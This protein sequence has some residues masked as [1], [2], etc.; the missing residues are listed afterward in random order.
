MLLNCHT[1]FSLRYGL[2]SVDELFDEVEKMGYS[3]F[4]LTDINNTSACM[5]VLRIGQR[6]QLKVWIGIDFRNGAEQKYVGI[7]QNMVGFRE[8]NEHLTHH[9]H[10]GGA[11]SSSA[12]EFENAYVVYP[13]DKQPVFLRENEFIGVSLAQVAQLG[14]S[15]S[16]YDKEK[17]VILHST[18][19]RHKRDF[20]AHRLL[21]AVGNNCLLSQLP[22]S[23]QGVFDHRFI[24][25]KELLACYAEHPY[26]IKN[27]ERLMDVPNLELPTGNRNKATFLETKAKDYQFLR[28]LAE[29]GLVYRYGDSVPKEVQQRMAKELGMIRDL[30]FCAYFLI[31]WDMLNY[32]RSK[33]YFH[34]GR[35]SGA[36]SLVAYLLRITDVDPVELN[37]YFERFINPHRRKPPDFD[38]DFSWLDR[39]DVTKYL[40]DRYS[41]SNTALLGTY[42]TFKARSVIRELG[43]VFGLPD[44]DIKHLQSNPSLAAA[45]EYGRLVLH[46]AQHIA[47][48]PNNLSVHASGILISEQPICAYTSTFIPPKGYPTTQFDMHVAEDIGLHKFDILSQRGLGKI[49]DSVTLV[50]ENQ[51][52]QIDI[53]DI[54]RFKRD[55][56]IKESLKVGATIG[57]FYVE[58]PAMRSLLTKME[59]DDYLRLVAAS[60]IIRPGVAKSGMMREYILRYRDPKRRELAQKELPEFYELL[61]ETYGVMVYQEDVIKVAHLFAGLTLAEADVLRRGMSWRFKQRNEFKKV[62]AKFF[63]NCAKKGYDQKLV[64]RVW[65]QIESFANFAFAKGHSASYAVESYQALYLKVHY[66]LEYMVAALNNGGGFYRYE[67]YLHEARLHGAKVELPCVNRSGALASISGNIIRIG[68]GRINGMENSLLKELVAERESN[69]LYSGLRDMVARIAIPLEQLCLLIRIGAFAFTGKSKKELLW[70][71]HFLLGKT[72]SSKPTADLFQ[73]NAK[74]FELPELWQ[75]ELEQSFDEMEL[76]GFPL[77]D[78]FGL[79]EGE[80]PSKLV[81]A[82]LPEYLGEEVQIVGYLVHRKVTQTHEKAAMSFG[83]LLDLAG[84]WLDTV[85]FPQVDAR[86]KFR[87]PGC[88]LITGMVSEEFGFYTVET[89]K[90]ERLPNRNM[91]TKAT[92]LRAV[93]PE[94]P[95]LGGR[96]E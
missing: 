71:A 25:K 38:I 79:V 85:Q 14:L 19:F 56:K 81:V 84:Q 83:T 40:F 12:P 30:G 91:D 90:L 1:Q 5:D 78:P 11:F 96:A 82:D 59:A 4:A 69:G 26:I 77:C 41:W 43:K 23:E 45:D 13:L 95:V 76:L 87:G 36:N 10:S 31:N 33:G 75:H 64:R 92:R 48:L 74:E 42:S 65:E 22:I 46:Y 58:S 55:P 29:K 27:T 47:G 66:P 32:A 21:R 93:A 44:S 15:S 68:L 6:Y 57:C 61:E 94:V 20:N 49:K 9:L 8:L 50:K 73:L 52:V 39:D 72:R 18:T 67:L 70:D 89:R 28:R 54:A 60:S 2:L 88:Y 7:A 16:R 51:G 3:A 24:P 86:Y 35:G 34:V 62:E 80:L 17:L 37:L 53:H 63:S